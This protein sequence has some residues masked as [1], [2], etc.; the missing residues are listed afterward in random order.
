MSRAPVK[1][2][3]IS[4]T[5]SWGKYVHWDSEC[6][7]RCGSFS[8]PLC[9]LHLWGNRKIRE[10][11][12]DQFHAGDRIALTVEGAPAIAD[13][14]T[15]QKGV[16]IQ[17]PT[18]GDISLKGVRRSDSEAYLTQQIGQHMRNPVVHVVPLLLVAL[19]GA[20]SHPGYYSVPSHTLLDDVIMR[21]GGPTGEADLG[22]IVILRN[23]REVIKASQVNEGLTARKTL[24][25]MKITAGDEIVVGERS[26]QNHLNT[27]LQADVHRNWFHRTHSGAGAPM[28]GGEPLSSCG[29]TRRLTVP[30]YSSRVSGSPGIGRHASS[31]LRM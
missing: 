7:A 3:R 18:I 29:M 4:T 22:K 30:P 11:N 27:V 19:S 9:A 28:S 31:S 25:D 8:G 23:G 24:D 16:V 21:I 20:I 13:T 26:R 10:S 15:V 6:E 1:A 2:S 12:P 14:F 17:L 5:T